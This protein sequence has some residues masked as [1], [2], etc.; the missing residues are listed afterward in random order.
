MVFL[1]EDDGRDVS[2]V[3]MALSKLGLKITRIFSSYHEFEAFAYD[4][5][6]ELRSSCLFLD[7]NACGETLASS[8]FN[9]EFW[10]DAHESLRSA[11]IIIHSGAATCGE[12]LEG[13][14]RLGYRPHLIMKSNEEELYSSLKKI[15]GEKK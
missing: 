5:P 3:R 9:D 15:I 6:N 4:S 1:V 12:E 8:I 7:C 13:F 11:T 10:I 2:T 14:H